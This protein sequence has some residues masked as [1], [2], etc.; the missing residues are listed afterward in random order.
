MIIFPVVSVHPHVCGEL[1][2][3]PLSLRP[4]PVH[5]HVCGELLYVHPNPSVAVGSSPRVWGTQLIELERIICIGSSPRVWGTRGRFSRETHDNRFIP[6]CVGNSKSVFHRRFFASVHPH[7]CGELAHA[8]VYLCVFD[9]SSPRVWGT[10]G[11]RLTRN[12]GR[13]F[14]PTCVGNSQNH[15][16]TICLNS[17]HPHV[18]GELSE[19]TIQGSIT[20]VHPHV[21]GEL[22]AARTSKSH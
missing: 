11:W 4:H 18:C 7:V 19:T 5:P 22:E 16:E 9:G 14:I 20:S 12:P 8:D 21:C 6:T 17:V 10:R 3:S 1:A 2:S 15:A 13:R